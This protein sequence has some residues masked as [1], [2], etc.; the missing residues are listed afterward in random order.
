[1]LIHSSATEP[2]ERLLRK[3]DTEGYLIF[4]SLLSEAES[5][6]IRQ[7]LGP[8]LQSRYLGRNDFEGYKTERVYALLAKSPVFA[9]LISHALVLELCEAVLGPDFLLSACLAINLH[10]GETPQALHFDDSF[11]AVPRPRPTYSVTAFW[12]IDPFTAD[13]GA[14]EIIPRSHLW[15]AQRPQE[16]SFKEGRLPRLE[17]ATMTPEEY[18]PDLAPAIMP[19]GSLMVCMGTLWHRGGGNRSK[20]SRLAI[21]PL[22]SI[23]WARQQ[24]NM[25]LAVA[26]EIAA[27]YSERVQQLLGYSIHPPFMGHVNGLHPKRTLRPTIAQ[28]G[29]A[30]GV[31]DAAELGR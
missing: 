2:R 16:N 20:R 24:E 3:L 28:Q 29:A 14:T 9:E 19:G 4:P 22:Y 13:N 23:A 27:G 1:M 5:E 12:A 26:P 31:P 17:A 25:T 15:G 10:P 18:H 21:T 7:A 30:A 8:H 11:Y 6:N